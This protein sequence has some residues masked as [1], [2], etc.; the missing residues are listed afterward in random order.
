MSDGRH[1]LAP[2][3]GGQISKD[4][5][6][7]RAPNVSERVAIEEK[8]WRAAMALPQEV[9]GFGEGGDFGLAA[10]PLRFKRSIAL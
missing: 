5:I 2:A 7:H 8:K 4:E 1:H 10:A 6:D 9:Y 3:G